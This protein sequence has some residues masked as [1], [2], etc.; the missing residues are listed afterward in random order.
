MGHILSDCSKTYDVYSPEC[1]SLVTMETI[2]GGRDKDA[3]ME[4]ISSHV[5]DSDEIENLQNKIVKFD[6]LVV[7]KV[8]RLD[9]ALC[10]YVTT[11]TAYQNLFIM[12]GN[13]GEVN[14]VLS[15]LGVSVFQN[16][17]QPHVTVSSELKQAI[18]DWTESLNKPSKGI[19]RIF[20]TFF[21]TTDNL[22]HGC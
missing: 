21:C 3:I 8:S 13:K 10:D 18:D 2:T 22:M 4:A 17:W 7:L 20:N 15:S 1:S 14:R 12:G 9:S 16:T 5:S 19:G 11:L 6:G